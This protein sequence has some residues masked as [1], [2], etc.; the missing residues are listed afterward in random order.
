MTKILSLELVA[1]IGP[2]VRPYEAVPLS[3][4]CRLAISE[5]EI[6]RNKQVNK[7]EHI[8]EHLLMQRP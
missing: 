4:H 3:P 7:E 5:A 8:K 1:A 6:N 2:Q